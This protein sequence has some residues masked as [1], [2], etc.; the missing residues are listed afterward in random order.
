MVT[1]LCELN[2]APLSSNILSPYPNFIHISAQMLYSE[3]IGEKLAGSCWDHNCPDFTVCERS[4]DS[5]ACILNV[6]PK[7]R[8]AQPAPTIPFASVNS[9]NESGDVAVYT[10]NAAYLSGSPN[11][12][13][14][15]NG[16][17]TESTL[18]CEAA[19]SDHPPKRPN[20]IAI[21]FTSQ[22]D[23]E[24]LYICI[25][26][27]RYRSGHMVSVCQNDGTWST[28]VT[29]ICT[30]AVNCSA[31]D[32]P[33]VFGTERDYNDT[34]EGS[35]AIY[36]CKSTYIYYSGNFSVECQENGQWTTISLVCL[37]T[38]CVQTTSNGYIYQGNLRLSESGQT[39]LPFTHTLSNYYD[40][41]KFPYDATMDDVDNK[42]R[43]TS[44]MTPFSRPWCYVQLSIFPLKRK[45][46]YCAI[47][48]C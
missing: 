21:F 36:E 22:V 3:G 41:S 10:C 11:I 27:Y 40:I 46:E 42:C 13:C 17:W 16:E 23:S 48:D 19:C 35:L 45:W 4:G 28:N 5:F 1:K 15:A 8:C 9:Y 12:S 26:G 37:P 39:C 18:Q 43:P 2:I 30:V 29:I 31:S 34:T 20:T 33:D 32:L 24:V 44:D 47:P 14:R 7:K 38:A 6:D 25:K